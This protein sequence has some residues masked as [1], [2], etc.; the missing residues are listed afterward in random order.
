MAEIIEKELS[1]LIMQAAS[2]VYDNL[3][4]G[5]PEMIYREAMVRELIERDM[6]LQR[7]RRIVVNYKEQPLGE[8]V[9]DLVANGRII[10]ELK[11][12]SGILRVH[13]QQAL[14]YLKATGLPLAIII[15]FGAESLQSSRVVN[16]KGKSTLPP[17]EHKIRQILK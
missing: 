8:F 17:L 15:N 9:L 16:P 12:D 10:L 6:I 14:S 13:E 1:D 7:Q 2:E 5:F 3:G 4:P 11:A